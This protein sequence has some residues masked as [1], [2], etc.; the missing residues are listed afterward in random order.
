MSN[1]SGNTL[2]AV[3]AGAALGIGAGMLLAPEEG[4]KTRKKIKDSL[5]DA[6][7]ELKK[8]VKNLEEEVKNSSKKTKVSL[9]EKIENIVDKGSHKAEEVISIL[10]K[11]LASLK[12]TNAKLQK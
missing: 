10:E 3:I 8:K 6:T 12:E 2:L 4:K 1:N 5:D 9:E 7:S 11:K